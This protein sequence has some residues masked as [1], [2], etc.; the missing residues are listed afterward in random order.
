MQSL[1]RPDGKTFVAPISVG[2]Y[3]VWTNCDDFD[4]EHYN[5]DT[6][7]D[8]NEHN[9]EDTDEEIDQN[10]EI[11]GDTIEGFTGFINEPGN[12][13]RKAIYEK[14]IE[15]NIDPGRKPREHDYVY[16]AKMN[17]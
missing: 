7:E 14:Q 10:D 5:E 11:T 8:T 2:P 15:L 6:N 13:W 12:E 4:D 3:K 17:K 9:N 1:I 16:W